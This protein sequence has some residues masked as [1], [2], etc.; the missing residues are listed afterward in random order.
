MPT[1]KIYKEFHFEM[2]NPEIFR[3]IFMAE[4]S[5]IGFEGFTEE[6][7]GFIAYTDQELSPDFL[8][9]KY[10]V[11]FSYK[12]KEIL[13][14]NWNKKWEEQIT[15]LAIDDK[16]YIRTSFHPKKDYP[17]KITID[18][19]MSF[20]TG[21]HETTW[22]MIKQMLEIDFT[23]KRVLDMGAGTGV[24]SI[25][26]EQMG[27]KEIVA[28]DIDEWAFENMKEN[29]EINKTNNITAFFGGSELLE[30]MEDFDIILANINLNIL[31]ENIPAYIPK[32]KNGGKLVLSGFLEEDIIKLKKQVLDFGITFERLMEKG[33][34]ISLS[35]KKND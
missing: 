10:P 5:E 14:Q 34:W 31:Q 28:I 7:N 25:L 11:N 35:F 23:G 4:L 18:P 30:N 12:V 16:V 21:H 22:L 27:A 8:K 1:K 15:P 3:D 13:P 19:K 17:F 32:L 20:G 9:E 26:A 29:F 6:P 2:D 33:R 24:L